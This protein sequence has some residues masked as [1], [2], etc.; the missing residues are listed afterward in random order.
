MCGSL[1]GLQKQ[2]AEF[3]TRQSLNAPIKPSSHARPRT[4]IDL[5]HENL[6][7]RILPGPAVSQR[8]ALAYAAMIAT[9]A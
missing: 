7:C 4:N 5:M 3:Q 6:S 2:R 9:E 8:I 1:R